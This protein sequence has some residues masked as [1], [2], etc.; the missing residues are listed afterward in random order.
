[1]RTTLVESATSRLVQEALAFA[2][3]AHAGQVRKYTGRPY[4]THPIAV[5]RL[6][7]QFGGD[8]AMVAAALLHDT[9]EDCGVTAG[10]LEARFGKDVSALVV[11]LTDVSRPE[12][13]NRAA[14]KALDLAHTAN[15]SPRAK[16]IKALDLCHNTLSIVKGST[17]FAQVY[18]DE[19]AQLLRVLGDA[20]HCGAFDL[21]VRVYERSRKKLA[22]L[23]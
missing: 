1:M 6:V 21:A 10:E 17:R 12:N 13:G 15:A 23:A 20:S 3:R 14:R 19:K 18:L 2:A 9:I 4:I 16:T 8:S 22:R 7:H 5:A 11:H